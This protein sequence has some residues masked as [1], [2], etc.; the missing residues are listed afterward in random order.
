MSERAI[1]DPS[2][3]GWVEVDGKWVWD[4]ESGGGA[5][6][7]MVISETEPTDKVEGMQWLN[8]TTGLV[9]FW[10]DEKWLQ[11]PGGKDGADGAD[12]AD[13]LWIDN[14]DTT[15][16]Y[17]DG[18]VGIGTAPSFPLHVNAGATNSAARIETT[19]EFSLLSFDNAGTTGSP[20]S[21]GSHN[22]DFRLATAGSLRMTIDEDGNVG[23]G[24]IKP[25]SKLHVS[26][27]SNEDLGP[28]SIR[29]GGPTK[30]T[31]QALITKDTTTREL[32]IHAASGS[33]KSEMVF[34]SNESEETMRIGK[35]GRVDITGSL[36]VNGTP[37]VGTIDLIKAFSKLRDAV[38]DEDTVEALKGSITNCIGGLIEEWESMQ[39]STQEI[40]NE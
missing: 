7:G 23:I 29:L 36:Y 33:S 19:N 25:T 18:N 5:G 32:E 27:P 2:Q 1:A 6:A 3:H 12:G 8:P 34:Y 17:M 24:G 11:M 16:S 30:N 22:N 28:V 35:D 21:V 38:K 39:A 26:T 10:D 4:A 40:S 9:L 15:I 14:G 20:P 31:R 13:G 37:K